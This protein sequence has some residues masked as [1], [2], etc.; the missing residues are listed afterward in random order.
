MESHIL[1]RVANKKPNESIGFGEVGF[2]GYG[3]VQAVACV[4]FFATIR[5]VKLLRFNR[6]TSLLEA[7]LLKAKRFL[8][9]Y[10]I[11]FVIVM[12]GFVIFA[13]LLFCTR[14]YDYRQMGSAVS[15]V[16]RLLLGKYKFA[17]YQN[18]HHLLGPV[19]F[20]AFNM[21]S[22]WVMIN[23]MISILDDASAAVKKEQESI[24]SEDAEAMNL[25][26]QYFKGILFE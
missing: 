7:T 12:S 13:F 6:R 20:M 21:M 19:F 1:S 24:R 16:I 3:Y 26:F 2:W 10:A 8:Y 9:S 23:M 14:I 5:L 17:D 15:S 4:N 11:I 22:N 18:A 25:L